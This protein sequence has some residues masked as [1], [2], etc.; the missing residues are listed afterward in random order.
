[1]NGVVKDDMHANACAYTHTDTASS[2]PYAA[3][4]SGAGDLTLLTLK[5]L[6]L[7]KAA[8]PTAI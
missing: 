5:A 7:P 2:D 4:R 3:L 1:M 6:E 8:E